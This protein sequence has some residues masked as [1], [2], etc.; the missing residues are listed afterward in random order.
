MCEQIQQTKSWLNWREIIVY[1]ICG[2]LTTLVNFV[3]YNLLIAQFGHR[4]WF[5]LNAIAIIIS[6]IFAYAVNRRYVFRSKQA[7][8]P[9]ICSFFISRGLISLIFEQGGMYLLIEILAFDP[10]STFLGI[11]LYWSKILVQFL[12]VAGNYLV[13]K[14]FVFKSDYE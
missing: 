4:Y 10:V 6:I 11:K 1:L 2:V 12:V 9:E 3:C 7:V 5:W 13:G 8:L 14:L